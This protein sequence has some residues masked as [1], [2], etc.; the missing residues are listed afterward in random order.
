LAVALKVNAHDAG[1]HELEVLRR[2]QEITSDDMRSEF[3][4]RMLDHFEVTGPNGTHLCLVLELMCFDVLTLFNGYRRE[5][6]LRVHLAKKLAKQMLQ[7]L[8]VLRQ[9]GVIHN[10]KRLFFFT[11]D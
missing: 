8:E 11:D 1:R 10:G 7:G 5:P 6:N 9:C 3:I 4:V 2:I